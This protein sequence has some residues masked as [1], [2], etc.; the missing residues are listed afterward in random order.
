MVQKA[1]NVANVHRV[2]VRCDHVIDAI[3]HHVLMQSQNVVTVSIGKVRRAP[4]GFV[5]CEHFPSILTH[6]AATLDVLKCAYAKALRLC[7]EDSKTACHLML[8]DAVGTVSAACACAVALIDRP[9]G[10]AVWVDACETVLLIVG[11][12]E[13]AHANAGGHVAPAARRLALAA[14]ELIFKRLLFQIRSRDVGAHILK[15][16]ISCYKTLQCYLWSISGHK[17]KTIF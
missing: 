7:V 13:T 8:H 1:A 15:Q 11:S 3:A 9:H 10:V 6:E 14:G 16:T 12:T 4:A 17:D 2:D 5:S